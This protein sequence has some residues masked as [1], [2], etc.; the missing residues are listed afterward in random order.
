MLHRTDNENGIVDSCNAGARKE[1][2]NSENL[3]VIHSEQTTEDIENVTTN[4][5]NPSHTVSPPN[6]NLNDSD[7]SSD[8][9]KG[10]PKRGRKR[11][12]PEY[13]L[14]ERK[15][16]RYNNLPYQGKTKEMKAK[17]FKDYKCFCN[18]QCNV[19]LDSEKRKEEFRKFVAL[20]SYEA[21][22]LFIVACVQEKPKKREY[23]VKKDASVK[24]RDNILEP[25][26]L[27]VFKYARRCF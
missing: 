3:N 2:D 20:G 18:R 5:Q 17:V 14:A 10:R 19:L 27:L 8:N 16:R 21:Q 9:P 6:E 7:E 15:Q 1:N 4:T 12:F 11:K 23:A 26:K 25:T 24:K 22:L 13:T